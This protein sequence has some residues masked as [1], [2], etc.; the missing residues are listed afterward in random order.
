MTTR[1]APVTLLITVRAKLSRQGIIHRGGYFMDGR[2]T[3]GHFPRQPRNG[4]GEPCGSF[5]TG[6][7]PPS[8]PRPFLTT[9]PFAGEFWEL[10]SVA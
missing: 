7:D 9:Y 4:D 1:D 3:A 5:S 2:Y 10:R 8:R 6:P